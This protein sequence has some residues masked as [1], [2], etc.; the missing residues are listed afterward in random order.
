MR[1]SDDSL[2]TSRS[3]R[4][5]E[6]NT[7]DNTLSSISEKITNTANSSKGF[8]RTLDKY[9]IDISPTKIQEFR[10]LSSMTVFAHK[11]L[12]GNY[13]LETGLYISNPKSGD[14]YGDFKFYQ[15]RGAK[16][17][18]TPQVAKLEFNKSSLN[19]L[20]DT[21]HKVSGVTGFLRDV[22]ELR[23]CKDLAVFQ[24]SPELF[25]YL[26]PK[27]VN[28]NGFLTYPNLP[29][30][31]SNSLLED[32]TSLKD[33]KVGIA[34]CAY[35]IHPN[36]N[37]SLIEKIKGA[38]SLD[39]ANAEAKTFDNTRTLYEIE[40]GTTVKYLSSILDLDINDVPTL[41]TL[42][43]HV[44][45]HLTEVYKIDLSTDKIQLFFH[46]PVAAE[47]AT[48]HLHARVNKADHPLNEARSF[49]LTDV[50][51]TLKNGGDINDMILERNNGVYYTGIHE[52]VAAIRDIPNK[53]AV[54][55][56]Y[57]LTLS[58]PFEGSATP[59]KT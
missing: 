56:P 46:F 22:L 29:Y 36:Q 4:D 16:K 48:L 52:S 49:A 44:L 28:S 57:I 38:D 9:G 3:V 59:L 33:K 15:G 23:I 42:R 17:Y 7:I 58:H 2:T 35:A 50:I 12:Q 8:C 39:N 51:N 55:N 41:E 27:D 1:V 14:T 20:K 30:I 26:A 24:N 34:L 25:S 43:E 53:G 6:A 40:S 45:V 21:Y 18:Q 32:L 5:L 11:D 31:D 10:D 54:D 37:L 47:T 13:K 19:R